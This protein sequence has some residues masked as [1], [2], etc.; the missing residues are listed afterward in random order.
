MCFMMILNKITVDLFKNNSIEDKEKEERFRALALKSFDIPKISKFVLG[1]NWRKA[2]PAQ[3]D[4][5]ISVF[6]EVNLQRFMPLFT[7]YSDQKFEVTSVRVDKDK[8]SLF[9]VSSTLTRREGE[10][11]LDVDRH[12]VHT[13][14]LILDRVFN[15][16]DFPLRRIDL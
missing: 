9:F 1:R 13:L 4:E 2:S 3:R 5:F 12:L 11:A 14:E 15:G 16:D 6:G 7:E 8:P 10:P